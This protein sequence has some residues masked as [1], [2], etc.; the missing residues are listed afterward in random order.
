MLSFQRVLN[1]RGA[2]LTPR[3][4]QLCVA[5]PFAQVPMSMVYRKD[6]YPDGLA[7]KQA[8][9]MLYGYG[10]YGASIEPTFDFTRCDIVFAMC[11]DWPD[12]GYS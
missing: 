2:L 5:P 10:S 9:C 4:S 11:V 8:P 12:I 3:I 1:S 7:G 6:V